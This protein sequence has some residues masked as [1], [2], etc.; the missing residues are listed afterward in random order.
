MKKLLC[1]LLAV[2]MSL[3]L[4]ACGGD[5]DDNNDGGGVTPGGGIPGSGI[6]LPDEPADDWK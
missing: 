1:L 2:F 3:S 5:D 4:I 6:E